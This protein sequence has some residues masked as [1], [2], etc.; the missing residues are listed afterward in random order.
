VLGITLALAGLT[1]ADAGRGLGAAHAPAL[2]NPG[3]CEWEGEMREWRVRVSKGQL[4]IRHPNLGAY[5]L[6]VV[7]LPNGRVLCNGDT[8]GRYALAGGTL[9]IRLY[10]EVLF[11][12]PSARHRH[13]WAE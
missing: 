3:A 6:E 1:A 2:V 5:F 8:E 10:G 4:M 13:K 9:V 11:L 12:R 7:F